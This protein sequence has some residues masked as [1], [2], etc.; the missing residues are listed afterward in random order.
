MKTVLLWNVTPC[1]LV[2]SHQCFRR[3]YRN[4]PPHYISHIRVFLTN[5]MANLYGKWMPSSFDKLTYRHRLRRPSEMTL[6]QGWVRY[7]PRDLHFSETLVP[8][9]AYG[10]CH[11]VSVTDPYGRILGFL[12]RSR[13]FL[14]QVAPQLFLRSW[15]E[16]I[17]DPLL[18][19]KSGSIGNRTRTSGSVAKNLTTR[20]QRR[21]KYH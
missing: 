12:G 9:F 3:I 7:R 20:P 2:E 11:V 18:L 21:P 13:Y 15:V 6:Q 17:P 1:S 8:T 10:R 19:R 4:I 5:L 16:P 14:F